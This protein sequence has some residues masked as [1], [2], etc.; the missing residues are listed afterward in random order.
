M[1]EFFANIHEVSLRL[2]S[3]IKKDLYFAS[4]VACLTLIPG[5]AD[6]EYRRFVR[7]I[8]DPYLS[9]SVSPSFI[10]QK[11]YQQPIYRD[12][13]HHVV[14]VL[15]TFIQSVEMEKLT[16]KQILFES[17]HQTIPFTL[18]L[19]NLYAEDYGMLIAITDMCYVLISSLKKLLPDE[20]QRSI[21]HTY[22]ATFRS[23]VISQ[24]VDKDTTTGTD[25]L[26][27]YVLI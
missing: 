2:D 8:V 17:I 16:T 10:E 23:D 24:I 25:L 1:Q 19:F 27:K 9:L 4:S 21:L 14:I 13:L 7:D 15:T 5:S 11:L 22:F 6:Q 3:D 18:Q 20:L 12:Q 26:N